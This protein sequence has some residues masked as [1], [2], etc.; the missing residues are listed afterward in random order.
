MENKKETAFTKRL[1]LLVFK[2]TKYNDYAT[3]SP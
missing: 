2:K 1:L 3:G